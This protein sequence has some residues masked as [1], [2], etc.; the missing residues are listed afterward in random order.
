M[1]KVL[2][3]LIFPLLFLSCGEDSSIV[4]TDGDG[5]SD[6]KELEFFNPDVDPISYNPNISDLPILDINIYDVPRVDINYVETSTRSTSS[7]TSRESG[8]DFSTSIGGSVSTTVSAS[9]EASASML[10]PGVKASGTVS[11]TVEVNSEL[12]T[13]IR[14]SITSSR[15]QAEENSLTA[16]EARI[17]VPVFIENI[18]NMPVSVR[19]LTLTAYSINNY[20]E[21]EMIGSL[22]NE[23]FNSINLQPGNDP[24]VIN[25]QNS[26]LYPSNIE[27]IMYNSRRIIVVPTS[28]DMTIVSNDE[29][30][31][32][33]EAYSAVEAKTSRLYFKRGIYDV[34]SQEFDH[35]YDIVADN[36]LELFDILSLDYTTRNGWI[37]SLGGQRGH[38]ILTGGEWEVRHTGIR[39]GERFETIYNSFNPS[40]DFE[41][42]P[43]DSVYIYRTLVEEE[44]ESQINLSLSQGSIEKINEQPVENY[45]ESVNKVVRLNRNSERG[46]Y[47]EV[48][49]NMK[50]Q[51]RLEIQTSDNILFEF[52]SQ[53]DL[54]GGV[55]HE[56]DPNDDS[57]FVR[58][59]DR[60]PKRVFI[61]GIEVED[62]EFTH[63]EMAYDSGIL[64]I[65]LDDLG[66]PPDERIETLDFYFTGGANPYVLP[67][68][69]Q[70]SEMGKRATWY[71]LPHT[72]TYNFEG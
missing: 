8:R 35:I 61:N 69:P 49:L 40:L 32:Y 57:E 7:S 52:S 20:G 56:I 47:Q 64:I 27:N 72:E 43:A 71:N 50:P 25:F 63:G 66:F 19:D 34:N 62:F 31:D 67:Y 59:Y 42:R 14:N 4:D 60:S 12:S 58:S 5:M 1:K 6:A 9:V 24:V 13:S 11:G 21:M 23:Y 68:T 38:N 70:S 17:S 41:I 26:D 22:N 37:H 15:E 16:E 28:Y 54:G 36:L 29:V 10:D 45:V 55:Y 39:N 65:D 30:V 48:D 53:V 44:E 18:G 51:R 33:Y 3:L 46:V 2:L